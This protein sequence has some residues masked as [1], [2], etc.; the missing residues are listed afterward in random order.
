MATHHPYNPMNDVLFKFI[1]GSEERKRITIDFIN[2]VLERDREHEII[3]IEF[4]NVEFV[5]LRDNDKLTSLDV[6]CVSEA[7]ARLD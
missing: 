1:F 4:K 3:D 2:S 7:G 5:P 6:F